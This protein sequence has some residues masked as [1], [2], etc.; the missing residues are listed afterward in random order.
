MMSIE[1]QT[2]PTHSIS[3]V[4]P[5]FNEEANLE[6]TV[7]AVTEAARQANIE[8]FEIIIIDDRSTDGTG[9]LMT[10]LAQNNSHIVTVSNE[11]NLG[12]GGAY[13][14]GLK[15][16]TG[17]YT[18]MIPGDNVHPAED[19]VPILNKA[20]EAD[21]V[22]PY[23]TNTHTRPW[24]RRA[25]SRGFT[26]L[27]NSLFHLNVPY[28]N[29]NVLHRTE[30]L[31][32]VN[33]TTDSFA[34]QAEAIVKLLNMGATYCTVAV[35]LRDHNEGRSYA[36]APKNVYRVGTAVFALWQSVTSDAMKLEAN[37]LRSKKA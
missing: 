14:E 1:N 8:C 31:K 6:G 25:A 2:A 17:T 29:G 27:I 20:G 30:L 11:V 21:M 35:S 24:H 4:V 5:C 10:R 12:L 34:Y 19:I 32:H 13:K 23:V 18:I 15:R 22:I 28:F 9:A 37:R 7:D 33:I 36:F 26:M 16:A 3:F